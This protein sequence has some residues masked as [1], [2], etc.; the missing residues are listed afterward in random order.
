M[1]NSEINGFEDLVSNT[2]FKKWILTNDSQEAT[3]WHQ[4]IEEN[5]DKLEWVAA[6][7]IMVKM[8]A[9][10]AHNVPQH[11]IDIAA[12]AI[13]EKIAA[14]ENESLV[15]SI[16]DNASYSEK[17]ITANTKKPVLLKRY[18]WIAAASIILAIATVL[19]VQQ[20]NNVSQFAAQSEYTAF[21]Q[22]T[23]NKSVEYVN[24]SD[25]SQKIILS[26]SSEVQLEMHSRLTF[27]A[28]KDKRELFLSGNGFFKVAH[29][30]EQPFIV[31]TQNIVTKVLGTS[32]YIKAMPGDNTPSVTVRTGKVSVYR[33]ENFTGKDAKPGVLEGMVLTPNQQIVFDVA[34]SRISKEIVTTPLPAKNDDISF[35]FDATP[36]TKVFQALQNAY[37]IP[38]LFDEQTIATCSITAALDKESFYDKLRI[39]CKII[40]AN[41]EI[42]DGSIVINATG[43][44]AKTK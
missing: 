21:L 28:S 26:D 1:F 35:D 43:C 27:A 39:I 44:I 18:K 9:D 16:E 32:F 36:A 41:Y 24:N 4:W 8:L 37:G 30:P 19:V 12:A 31:Y 42:T 13:Q 22:K 7:K 6:A 20:T 33:T 5:P 14:L 40:N 34:K 3:H 23:N 17:V 15:I 2:S 10:D 25:S 29:N 38:I 11:E